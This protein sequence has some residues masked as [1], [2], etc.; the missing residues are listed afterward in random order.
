EQQH[1]RA[2]LQERVRAAVEE[3]LDLIDL[4]RQ[5]NGDLA[6]RFFVETRQLHVL[7][8]R[9]RVETQIVLQRL[10]ETPPHHLL[11]ILEDRLAREDGDGEESEGEE[12]RSD[13][14]EADRR[15]QR[16]AARGADGDAEADQ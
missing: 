11:Q 6:D 2:E 10:R 9:V 5:R 7:H 14:R 15:E 16:R 8:A 3:V 1:V 13:R 4:L 12:L